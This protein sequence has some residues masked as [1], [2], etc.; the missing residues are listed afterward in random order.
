MVRDGVLALERR[1]S[2][3][4]VASKLTTASKSRPKRAS[5]H[6]WLFIDYSAAI[7]ARNEIF[8]LVRSLI[9]MPLSGD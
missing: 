8:E 5:S 3:T 7:C 4:M 1:L 2:C 6:F 9:V